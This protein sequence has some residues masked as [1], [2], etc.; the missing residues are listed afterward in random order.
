MAT[1]AT[2]Y[3]QIEPSMK[4]IHGKLSQAMGGEA[5]TA[6][7]S[8]GKSFAGKFVS[9]AKKAIAV[10]GIGKAI[11]STISSGANYEQ[12]VGGVETLFKD[13]AGIIKGYA[14]EAYKSC[15]LSANAYM[16]QSTSF[17]AS[18]VS[19]CGGNTKQAAEMANMALVDM[20]DNANKMGTDLTSIQYAYQGFAKQNYTML[21]NLKLGYGGTK[22]EMERLL[23]DA[24]AI[25]AK[26]GEVADYSIDSY[27][28]VVEA[29]HVVQE[30]MGITGTTQKEAATTITGSLGMVKG[31]W[32]NM[33]TA[34]SQN[35]GVKKAMGDLGS[36]VKTFVVG[37]L[38]PMVGNIA[39]SLPQIVQSIGASIQQAL[40]QMVSSGAQMIQNFASGIRQSLPQLIPIAM[41]AL[42][43]FSGSLRQNV[44]QIVDAGL[45]LIRSLADSL[46]QN[47]PV[48][49][50]TVP[51]IITNIAGLINDNAPKLLACG[52]ELIGKLGMGLIKAIPTLI[53]NIPQIIESIVSVFTAFNWLQIGG[54][55]MTKLWDGIKSVTSSGISALKSLVSGGLNGVKSLFSSVWNAI[56]TLVSGV[57]DEIKSNIGNG[58]NSIKSTISSILNAIKGVFS[59]IWSGI[60]TTVGNV[61]NGVKSTISS[62]LNAAKSTVTSVLNSIKSAFSNIWNGAK[63]IVSGAISAIKNL[64]NFHWELPK[65]KLPHFSISGK[66]SLNPPSIPH[67]GVEWYRKAMNKAMV[68][69]DATIFGA[70]GG[71]LLGGGE[72]SGRE[73]ISGEDHLMDLIN[74]TIGDI[75]AESMDKVYALLVQ[76]LPEC[77][78]SKVAVPVRSLDRALAE[79]A[80][81]RQ[82]AW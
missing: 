66:F 34:I 15:G 51:Q 21:D 61:I 50:Q 12:A 58:F 63:S 62:G 53:A 3:I 60:K 25:K 26:Q 22:T 23:A 57:V 42:V 75:L 14:A 74:S 13:S 81:R 41:E 43:S 40:P 49:I 78:K 19:A 71:K 27:A 82:E 54:T 4:G 5:G 24:E 10:A 56:K 77:A 73:V 36:S 39:K 79:N 69:S 38:L 33:L 65:L 76:Y 67:I 2:A 17:A 47:I 45:T 16:E 52:I 35:Q 55:I 80:N 48:F 46:I 18:L 9:F 44:G 7:E 64:M 6:G 31:A 28:D 1:L 8:S 37:N 20:S 70:A 32:T 68:L 30:E 29:I 59:N 11:T 72:A